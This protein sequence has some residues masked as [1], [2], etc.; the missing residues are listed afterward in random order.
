MNSAN[1]CASS[2]SN[3][4]ELIAAIAVLSSMVFPGGCEDETPVGKA[5]IVGAFQFQE[6]TDHLPAYSAGSTSYNYF[7]IKYGRLFPTPVYFP[8][9]KYK[10]DR[11]DEIVRLPSDRLAWL[12]RVGDSVALMTMGS[13]RPVLTPLWNMDDERRQGVQMKRIDDHRWY[14]PDVRREGTYPNYIERGGRLFNGMQLTQHWLPARPGIVNY[15]NG[16]CEFVSVSPDESSVAWFVV[17]GSSPVRHQLMVTDGRA[18]ELPPIDLDN[19]FMKR[20]PEPD[21]PLKNSNDVGVLSPYEAWFERSF[22]WT[23]GPDNRWRIVQ[24]ASR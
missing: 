20:N 19:E 12:L 18:P 16:R 14:I 21:I 3:M 13:E 6:Y 17:S 15:A 1:S 10:T 9:D 2:N 24:T 23:R 8:V 11:I 4:R 7:T 5:Q 22:H